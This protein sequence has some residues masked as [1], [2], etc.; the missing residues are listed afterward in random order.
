MLDG[1]AAQLVG[2]AGSFLLIVSLKQKDP[3]RFRIMNLVASALMGTFALAVGAWPS[4]S[5]NAMSVVVNAHEL[6]TMRSG[7]PGD[8]AAESVVSAAALELAA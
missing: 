3:T 2:W 1:M 5:V 8:D 4:F 6:W 7:A